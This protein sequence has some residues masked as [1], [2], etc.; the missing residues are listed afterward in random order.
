MAKQREL[1][2]EV[3]ANGSKILKQ[4][5]VGAYYR[6]SSGAVMSTVGNFATFIDEQGHAYEINHRIKRAIFVGR[7]EPP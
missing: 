4:E 1:V 6:S 5:H 2:Y 3:H 7:Q